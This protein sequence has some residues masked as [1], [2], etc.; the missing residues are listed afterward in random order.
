M[1]STLQI[2]NRGS[3]SFSNRKNGGI[4]TILMSLASLAWF[5]FLTFGPNIMREVA[6]ALLFT[7]IVGIVAA[8]G[9]SRTLGWLAFAAAAWTFLSLIASNAMANMTSF[10]WRQTQAGCNQFFDPNGSFSN[11]NDHDFCKTD[12]YLQYAR[13]VSVVAILTTLTLGLSVLGDLDVEE[14]KK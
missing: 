4:L 2:F 1:C 7:G 13:V 6:L 3:L 8:L 9:G 10:P 5:V 14:E 11:Y 12:G